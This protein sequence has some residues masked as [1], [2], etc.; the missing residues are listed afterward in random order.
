MKIKSQKMAIQKRQSH[1][2]PVMLLAA[3]LVTAILLAKMTRAA[4]LTQ[5]SVPVNPYNSLA[6]QLAEKQKGLNSREAALNALQ[7]RLEQGYKEVFAVMTGLF[8]LIIA[9]F[10]LDFRRRKKQAEAVSASKET[11]NLTNSTSVGNSNV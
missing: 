5:V 7:V 8:L 4:E 3:L 2:V 9:N 10:I 1:Q 6:A 11:K